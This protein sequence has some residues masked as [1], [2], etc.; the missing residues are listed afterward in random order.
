MYNNAKTCML[1]YD[2]DDALIKTWIV[3]PPF[4]TVRKF[5][6]KQSEH[7]T[8]NF[9]STSKMRFVEC[10]QNVKSPKDC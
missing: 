2:D 9:A 10:Q 8:I 6:W 4:Q 5:T 7:E 3:Q 1:L